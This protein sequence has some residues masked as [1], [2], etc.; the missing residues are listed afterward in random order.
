MRSAAVAQGFFGG[1]GGGGAKGAGTNASSGR[2]QHRRR[3]AGGNVDGRC[4]QA[5][6]ATWCERLGP[7]C[8]GRQLLHV[9][10]PYCLPALLLVFGRWGHVA[11]RTAHEQQGRCWRRTAEPR[12]TRPPALHGSPV[13]VP[14]PLCTAGWQAQCKHAEGRT[15]F[16]PPL[17]AHPASARRRGRALQPAQRA[18]T[19]RQGAAGAC[20]Q[21]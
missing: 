4:L 12:D 17:N 16:R 21:E 2:R 10:L 5:A 3:Q 6:H 7:C 19:Q 14:G 15:C 9:S 1:A 13:G 8:L 11:G 20:A 18:G